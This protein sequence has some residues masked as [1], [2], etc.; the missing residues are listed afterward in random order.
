MTARVL[1]L[2]TLEFHQRLHPT[3][4]LRGH[5]YPGVAFHLDR[6]LRDVELAEPVEVRDS[7]GWQ[8]RAESR[9]PVG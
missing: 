5:E 3:G 6:P 7:F 8:C 2:T 9:W 4:D 1:D